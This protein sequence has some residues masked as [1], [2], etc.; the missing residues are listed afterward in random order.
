MKK[1]SD[2]KNEEAIELWA[3]LIGPMARILGDEKTKSLVK[4]KSPIDIAKGILAEHKSDAIEIMLRIDD[5]P[6]DGINVV[7]RL[8]GIILEIMNNE[9]LRSFFTSAGQETMQSASFG[10]AMENIKAIEKA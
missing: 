4:T 10:S 7:T 3:D 1:L 5:T 2:Y 9:D 6:V 8:V